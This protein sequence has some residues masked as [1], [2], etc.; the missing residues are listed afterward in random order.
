MNDH[1]VVGDE[2]EQR[3]VE[4]CPNPIRVD[5][6]EHS[7]KW[8]GDD[9]RV[10]CVGCGELRD[11]HSGRVYRTGASSTEPVAEIGMPCADTRPHP[12]H[13]WQMSS[14]GYCECAGVP[15]STGLD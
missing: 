9:P 3:I 10:E 12:R 7:W 5:G 6:P 14:T 4:R 1:A 2:Y 11:A 8:D 13:V 15:E